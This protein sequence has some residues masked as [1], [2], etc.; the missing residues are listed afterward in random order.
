MRT[1]GE[2]IQRLVAQSEK[3]S[4]LHR[5]VAQVAPGAAVVKAD[6]TRLERILLNLIDN[7]VKYSPNGGEVRVFAQNGESV[8]IFGVSDQGIGI[9]ETDIKRLFEPFQRVEQSVIGSSIQGIGLGLVVCRRLV[10]AHGGKIWVQSEP[11]KGSTF[12]FTI[13]A[14]EQTT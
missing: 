1:A 11:G 5:L 4:A 9:S 12:Y 6:L 8:V 7:A 13:P 14:W 2:L 3:K 10:E